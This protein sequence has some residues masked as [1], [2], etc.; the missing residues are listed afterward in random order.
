ANG[1]RMSFLMSFPSDGLTSAVAPKS[2]TI[3]PYV[4]RL[5]K[6]A[7]SNFWNSFLSNAINS[8]ERAKRSTS[9]AQRES[10]DRNSPNAHSME[11]R[12]HRLRRRANGVHQT[13]PRPPCRDIEA[14]LG[15]LGAVFAITGERRVDQPVVQRRECFIADAKLFADGGGVVGD[16]DICL[17]GKP[18]DR[19]LALRFRHIDREAA[20]VART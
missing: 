13:R 19:D 7:R 11:S 14:R 10:T 5:R 16:E 3:P 17:R 2:N 12:R 20:L 9:L 18:L 1:M 6:F 8:R 4:R 15:R